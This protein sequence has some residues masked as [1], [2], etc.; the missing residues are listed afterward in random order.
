MTDGMMKAVRIFEHG[1]TDV[2]KV[3][4]YPIPKATENDVLVKVMATGVSGWDI[5]YRRGDFLKHFNE[6]GLPGRK[7]FP[8]PQQLGREASGIVVQSGAQVTRFK[9]GD[10]VL[11]LVHPQNDYCINTIRGLGNLSTEIDYPGHAAFGGNAQYICRPE[12]YWLPIPKGVSYEQAA[13]G[14]WSFPTSHRI[15]VDRCMV[16]IGDTVF[17]TGTAGGMGNAAVQW[18]R[19]AGASVIGCTRKSE[20][21][22]PLKSLGVDLVVNTMDSSEA[23]D[24]I[25][26]LTHGEGI[27]HFIEFTGALPLLELGLKALRV[28]GTICPVGGDMNDQSLPFKVMDFTKKEMTVL[29]IRGSRLND[30]RI[31]LE[32]LATGK[33]SVP[34]AAILPLNDIQE[35][36]R[37]VENAEV[38]GKVLL[39]PWL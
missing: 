28:G 1:D 39:N 18:A 3:D 15:I 30:Q 19:L 23:Y 27:D 20:K 34:I 32:Q 10:A 11:G 2:L 14:S 13:A 21:I 12:N 8:L 35:A 5:K 26:E 4:K 9:P 37:M 7:K 31:Y 22:A 6:S 24:Q 33:I 17:I 36:H 16:S 38:V 25:M 29:G